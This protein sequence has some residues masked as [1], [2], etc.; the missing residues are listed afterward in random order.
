MNMRNSIC[1]GCGL[2]LK[3]DDLSLDDSYNASSACRQLFDELS[4]FS[5]SLRDK[6]FIH[7]LVVD[8][9]AAQHEGP[10]SKPIRAAFALIGLYLTFERGYTGKEVQ[11]AHMA[12]GKTR[13]EWPRFNPPAG[14]DALT[15]RDVLQNLNEA[16]YKEKINAWGRSV[17]ELWLSEHE[18]VKELVEKYLVT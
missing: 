16:N 17:W 12:L 7:Q 8:T 15:V 1:P 11:H 2:E 5:L 13:R 9:Y 6:D 10:N 4:A 3:S 14:K 18:T